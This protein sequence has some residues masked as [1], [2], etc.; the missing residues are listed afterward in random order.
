[1]RTLVLCMA[2]AAAFPNDTLRFDPNGVWTTE[3]AIRFGQAIE[4][5]MCRSRGS[6]EVLRA[7]G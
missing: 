1:M 4:T 6:P 5:I 3:Q 7:R 2:V